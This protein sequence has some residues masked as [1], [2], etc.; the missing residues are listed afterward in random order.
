M[1]AD[2]NRI[3]TRPFHPT[4]V[5]GDAIHALGLWLKANG[6]RHARREDL[7]SVMI[8]RYPAGFF[9]EDEVQALCELLKN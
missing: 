6:S 5:N 9:S 1:N 4:R 8:E 3:Y 2:I 7:R